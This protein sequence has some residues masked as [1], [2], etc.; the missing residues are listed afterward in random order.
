M[1]YLVE[2]P[3]HYDLLR[4]SLS[5]GD[6]S[7]FDGLFPSGFI[8]IKKKIKFYF[9]LEKILSKNYLSFQNFLLKISREAPLKNISRTVHRR[10]FLLKV[11]AQSPDEIFQ[12]YK[13]FFI[14]FMF[15]GSLVP[16]S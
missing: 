15:S 8:K 6:L 10:N 16:A 13:N 3:P 11:R 1:L 4:L 2:Q 5:T 12:K 14:F 9:D 7:A